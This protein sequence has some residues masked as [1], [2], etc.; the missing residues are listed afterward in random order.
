MTNTFG[1]FPKHYRDPRTAKVAIVPVPY[2]GTSTYGKGADKGPAALLSASYQLENYDIET[3]TEVYRHG[4]YVEKPVAERRSPEKMVAAV[5]KTIS[6]IIKKNK[7]CVML[8][9]EHSITP[10][11][12]R[13][14]ARVY[15][16]LTVLQL[17]AHTDMRDEYHGSKNNHACAMARIKKWKPVQVGIRSMDSSE[18]ANIDKNRLFLAKDIHDNDRWMEKAISKLSKNVYVTIDLDVFDPAFMPSTGTPEP[19]GLDWYQVT[20]FLKK[21]VSKRTV[22]GFDVVELLPRK[23]SPASNFVA[24]KLVHMFLSY[25]FSK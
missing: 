16:D 21:V 8:G 2:D 10:P 18:F 11:S 14:H 22:V 7:F 12:V 13:A 3:K 6:N 9:G 15:K 25:I 4:I 23:D 20:E 24:A 1:D 19:G 5:E 17:D